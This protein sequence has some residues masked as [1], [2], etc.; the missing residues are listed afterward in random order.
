[1]PTKSK[2]IAV[3]RDQSKTAKKAAAPDLKIRAATVR[4]V[5]HILRIVNDYAQQQA[6]LPRSP[7]S[8]YESIRDFYVAV[9]GDGTANEKVVGCGALHV[10]WGDLAEIRSIAVDPGEKSK[11]IGR[12]LAEVLIEEADRLLVPRL[13]AF[14]YVPGF[15][16]KL[17]FRVVE[18]SQLPY[19]VFADCMNCPKYNC[20][21]EIA[22]VRDLRP[23]EGT[24]PTTG[25]L[26]RPLPH[27]FQGNY[28]ANP[29]PHPAGHDPS[30][31]L[32]V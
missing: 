4:D 28:R 10:V 30:G 19:K 13:F 9:R 7:L 11:G 24:F 17:G 27:V 26:S 18:H 29:G 2:A 23:V 12:R 1:L 32:E 20:C 14:T 22:M 31:R 6:M 5:P 8:V 16:E 21:D 15:F 3:A 25:P